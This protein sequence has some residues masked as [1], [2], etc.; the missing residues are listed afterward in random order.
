MHCITLNIW[1]G[2]R[3]RALRL[4]RIIDCLTRLNPDVVLLQ[5]VWVN[6]YEESVAEYIATMLNMSFAYCANSI[7]NDIKYGNAILSKY[8]IVD[9]CCYQLPYG[10][11]AVSTDRS[12]SSTSDDG[13]CSLLRADVLYRDSTIVSVYSTHLSW[14]PEATHVRSRQISAIAKLTKLGE[15]YTILGGDFN[16]TH[17]S[18]EYKKVLGFGFTDAWQTYNKRGNKK[19]RITWDNR[20]IYAVATNEPDACLDYIFIK[21][22]EPLLSNLVEDDFT[23]PMS[24]HRAISVTVAI[25]DQSP[26]MS[27]S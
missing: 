15:R 12:D 2:Y 17:K 7:C 16:M 26:I 1:Y 22:F 25:Y 21:G 10:P 4:Q 19:H 23:Q 20:N 13:D 27:S 14:R 18:H 9:S 5:E 6:E 11:E 8:A 24:D 3:D